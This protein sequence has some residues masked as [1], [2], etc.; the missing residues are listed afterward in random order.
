[1]TTPQSEVNLEEVAQAI[2]YLEEVKGEVLYLLEQAMYL[3][4]KVNP[5][6]HKKA[7]ST[8][9][10]SIVSALGEGSSEYGLTDTIRELRKLKT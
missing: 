7:Q 8:W 9:C 5:D 4:E 1:M 2:N 10:S 6:A 3:V